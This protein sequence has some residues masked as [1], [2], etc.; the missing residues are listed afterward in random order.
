MRP[1]LKVSLSAVLASLALAACGGDDSSSSS[2]ASENADPAVA[3][4]EAGE[5]RAGLEAALAA[6]KAGDKAQA[7]EQVSEA[8]VSHYEEVE[9]ALDAKNHELNEKLEETI[10]GDLREAVA[11]DQPAQQVEALFATVFADLE[12]AEALL[13]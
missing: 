13:Q 11:S 6:Y 10:S 7:E 2:E 1:A 12:R 8:Y 3:L 4:K 5:T 9:A